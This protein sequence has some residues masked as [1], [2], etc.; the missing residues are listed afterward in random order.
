MTEVSIIHLS[1][2]DL[3]ASWTWDEIA[4]DID[5]SENDDLLVE[6]GP[7]IDRFL[8]R[9]CHLFRVAVAATVWGWEGP[10]CW[11][12]SRII[13]VDSGPSQSITR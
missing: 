11:F 6:A 3:I 8:N 12:R 9:F 7:W 2:L 1:F 13:S 4:L 5:L 10:S